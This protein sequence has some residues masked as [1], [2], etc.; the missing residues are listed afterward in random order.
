VRLPYPGF[1]LR[2][3]ILFL[4]RVSALLGKNLI[5]AR[6]ALRLS[7]QAALASVSLILHI[8]IFWNDFLGQLKRA[9]GRVVLREI[10]G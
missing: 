6:R 8:L 7:E 10:R 2:S 4:G 3:G 1:P 9:D 5:S